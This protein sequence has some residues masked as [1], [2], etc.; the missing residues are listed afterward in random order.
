MTRVK[1]PTPGTSADDV[2]AADAERVARGILLRQL[3][4]G[5]RT[6]AQLREALRK[7]NVPH[8]V[9]EDLLQRFT[10]V[11]LIDDRAY[12]ELVVRSESAGGG[13]SRRRVAQ[14]LRDKGVAEDVAAE[15]VDTIDPEDEAAAALDLARR[16]AKRTV[17]LDDVT[18]RRR[19]MGVLAR[20]G[21]D[22]GTVRWAVD[23]ALGEADDEGSALGED[24]DEGS[25]LGEAVE[26]R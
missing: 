5:P 1:G 6:E 10:D 8:D 23:I 15:A 12:A 21:F 11:G 7:R 25:A 24:D 22:H 17:G 13:L 20:R 2:P 4:A 14:R 18:R 26:G 16:R 3:T 19:L 9:A